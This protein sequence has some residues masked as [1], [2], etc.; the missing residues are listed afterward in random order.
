MQLSIFENN[1]QSKANSLLDSLNE[2]RKGK[3][4]FMAGC[5]VKYKEVI[6]IEA[7]NNKQ[8]VY[9]ILDEMGNFPKNTSACWRSL[10]H[11]ISEI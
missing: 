4:V 11:I 1:W 9:N 8:K 5:S 2:N 3:E 6:I 7:V 10:Q